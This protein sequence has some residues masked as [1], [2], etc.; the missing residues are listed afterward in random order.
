MKEKVVATIDS[1]EASQNP[2]LSEVI[3]M[4]EDIEDFQ[5]EPLDIGDIQIEN[6]V[7][8]RKTPSDFASSL[9]EGRLRDQVER[10]GGSDMKAFVLV[11]GDMDDFNDLEHSNM[12]SKSLRGM[13]AS[14]TVRNNIPVVFCSTEELL[15]DTAV[16]LAR[17]KE[18]SPVTVQPESTGAVAEVDFLTNVFMGVEG[19]GIQTAQNLSGLFDS[20]EEVVEADVQDFQQADNVGSVTANQIVKDIQNIEEVE[21]ED[22]ESKVKSIR[23]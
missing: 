11:P 9:E 15:A 16:R 2:D 3:V 5:I 6:C 1:N 8:E 4:H 21:E 18:E 7:F 13:V 22:D 10:M 19:V 20:L 12:P 17:K 14:I 23:I